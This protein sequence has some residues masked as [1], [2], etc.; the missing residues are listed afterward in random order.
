M[1]EYN[2]IVMSLE[3]YI[4]RHDDIIGSAI[5]TEVPEQLSRKTLSGWFLISR[6]T[7]LAS[8]MRIPLPSPSISPLCGDFICFSMP[9]NF[10]YNFRFSGCQFLLFLSLDGGSCGRGTLGPVFETQGLIICPLL[11][12]LLF[13]GLFHLFPRYFLPLVV[14]RAHGFITKIYIE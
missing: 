10:F 5:L 13:L 1:V 7:S 12:F 4:S 6:L 11:L 3:L 2:S 14:I 9:F 8:T